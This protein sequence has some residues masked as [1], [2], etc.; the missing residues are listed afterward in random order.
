MDVGG[1]GQFD[2][3][4]RGGGQYPQL[5]GIKFDTVSSVG[6]KRDTLTRHVMYARV[7]HV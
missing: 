4:G 3:P 5:T 7:Y 1:W 2:T 6:I